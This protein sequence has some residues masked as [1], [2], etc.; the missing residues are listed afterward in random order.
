MHFPNCNDFF[1]RSQIIFRIHFPNFNDFFTRM[2]LSRYRA[3]Y[4]WC[5]NYHKVTDDF[6]RNS[7][8][9][10]RSLWRE[11]IPTLSTLLRASASVVIKLCLPLWYWTFSF[12]A[13][14]MYVENY[15]L[16]IFIVQYSNSSKFISKQYCT[17]RS[18]PGRRMINLWFD[19]KSIHRKLNMLS[20]VS[21]L[22]NQFR[23]DF[24]SFAR[25]KYASI[26]H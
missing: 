19:S 23:E 8:H 2:L 4:L 17:Y 22:R 16:D 26:T 3:P 15:H 21:H 18:I 7:L 6:H 14:K 11:I 12:S 24:A 5:N 9:R 13:R 10:A 20:Y 25:R 1:T